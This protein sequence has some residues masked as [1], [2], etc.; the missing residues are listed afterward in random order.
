LRLQP[1]SVQTLVLGIG[2]D[3][4]EERMF[5]ERS[6]RTERLASLGTLA[7]GLAHEI[8]N[9]LNAAQLQLTL[10]ERRLSK[11]QE[12]GD[13]A[14]LI[15]DELL[16]LAHLV[17]DF[18]AFAKPARLRLEA[19]DLRST[20][21]TVLELCSHDAEQ[22]GV[23]LQMTHCADPVVVRVDEERIK[24]ILLN[25]IRNGMEAV[26]EQHGRVDV[27]LFQSGHHAVL[28]VADSGPGV[29]EGVSVFE[30]FSS[31]KA[32]GTGLG[33]PIVHRIASDH[34]GEITL[35]RLDGETVFRVELPIEGPPG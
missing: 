11:Q 30:P 17:Q 3:V 18:L 29:P 6:R 9:P 21:A 28:E 13:G 1:G 5:E 25:L 7:A 20:V 4:T 33:L 32:G 19:L 35:K 12:I 15:R 27:R 26:A 24:Q 2:I 31:S 23:N 14:R 10:L 16:R 34:G 8:R 22:N